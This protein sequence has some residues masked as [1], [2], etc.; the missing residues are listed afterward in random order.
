MFFGLWYDSRMQEPDTSS[1]EFRE[2]FLIVRQALLVVVCWIEKRYL[3][4][5]RSINRN[6]RS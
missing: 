3:G 4:G 2:F 1:D 5:S 6:R